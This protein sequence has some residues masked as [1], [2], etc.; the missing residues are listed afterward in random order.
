MYLCIGAIALTSSPAIASSNM[1]AAQ[2]QDKIGPMQYG[3]MILLQNPS[4]SAKNQGGAFV[5]SFQFKMLSTSVDDKGAGSK[6]LNQG[7][8]L[9]AE[10]TMIGQTLFS[11]SDDY[12]DPRTAS[13]GVG[14]VLPEPV[15]KPELLVVSTV[16]L[17]DI[18]LTLN[19]DASNQSIYQATG[20]FPTSGRSI[21]VRI[22]LD[23]ATYPANQ[24]EFNM[25]PSTTVRDAFLDPNA[26]MPAMSVSFGAEQPKPAAITYNWLDANMRVA[27]EKFESNLIDLRKKA[28]AGNCTLLESQ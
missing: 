28:L 23:G 10:F 24:T 4:Q 17:R 8:Y 6:A 2:V 18:D 19:K 20:D 16:K 27:R 15:V 26:S 25:L 3:Y 1:C 9:P 7:A 11:K 12:L 22:G 13:S 21:V 5:Q 14:F